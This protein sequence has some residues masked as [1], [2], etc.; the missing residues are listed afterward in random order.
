MRLKQSAWGFPRVLP[1]LIVLLAA[2]VRIHG[3]RWGLPDVFEEATPLRRAWEMWGWGPSRGLD[4]NPHFFNY[5]SLTIYLQFLG[6]GI[7][8]L[9]L[10]AAGRIHGT[11]DFRVLYITDPTP[12]LVM[13]RAITILF[14]AGTVVLVYAIGKRIGGLACAVPAALLL[15]LNPLHMAQSVVVE[16]DVPLTFFVALGLCYVLRIAA[17]REGQSDPRDDRSSQV[18]S[19]RDYAMAGLA[20]GLAASAKY[21]GAFLALP[22]LAGHLIA[23]R[24]RS[25]E[26]K[27]PTRKPGWNLLLLSG[28]VA[29]AAFAATSPFVF[30]D[31]KT[32]WHDLSFERTHMRLGQ[33][34]SGDES[35]WVFYAGA[36]ANRLLGWPSTLLLMAGL[37]YFLVAKRTLWALTL[38]AFLVPMWITIAS[39]NMKADRY[40][41]PLLPAAMLFCGGMLSEIPSI[42]G[43]RLK[44]AGA[45]TAAVA[46]AA[47]LLLAGQAGGLDAY[48]N[49]LRPDPRTEARK[50]IAANIPPG[51]LIVTETLGPE[52]LAPLQLAPLEPDVRARILKN[53]SGGPLYAVQIVPMFQVKPER[54]EVFYDLDLYEAADCIVTTSQVANRYRGDPINFR[55]QVAFYDSLG[56]RFRKVAEFTSP[57]PKLRTITLY[58][59][60][61]QPVAFSARRPVQGP[62]PLR[63]STTQETGEESFFYYNLGLDYA[64]FGFLDAAVSTYSMALQYKSWRPRVLEAW[65]WR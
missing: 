55:R 27:T 29:I 48:R 4:L 51:A 54:S 31:P 40:L 16:V 64:A 49:R 42:A 41:L 11:I 45:R 62:V 61:R 65:C 25:R 23:R 19:R 21:T 14:A 24:E 53:E 3:V 6:Q 5:P 36:L 15:A 20:V 12:F 47:V 2:V 10:A 33:F 59:N 50:W 37:A 44:K 52:L 17:A 63:P 34:G 30:L 58:R 57:A 26:K 9:L 35:T 46:G 38:A 8:Y 7:L 28:G 1:I 18:P 32:F 13:G 60:P 22:L 43:R 56:V 39:W